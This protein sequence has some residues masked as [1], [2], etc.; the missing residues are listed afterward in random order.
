MRSASGLKRGSRGADGRGG[1]VT[2]G[3]RADG[4]VA[5]LVR[6]D[7]GESCTKGKK[8]LLYRLNICFVGIYTAPMTSKMMHYLLLP[9]GGAGGPPAEN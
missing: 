8:C 1:N 6:G 4:V 5:R 2:P 3:P 7:S 9:A